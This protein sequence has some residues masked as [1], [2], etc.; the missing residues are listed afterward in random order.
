MTNNFKI[1]FYHK[2]TLIKKIGAKSG[3]YFN[4]IVGSSSSSKVIIDEN[5]ISAEHIQI[6]FSKEGLFIQD[7][8]SLNGTYVNGKKIKALELVKIDLNDRINLTKSENILINIV[9]FSSTT[10]SLNDGA[11]ENILSK[12][13]SVTIG[14]SKNCDIVLE[15][16]SISR[17]H[18]TIEK[19]QNGY[20]IID[21]NSLN[22]IFINGRRIKGTVEISSTDVIFIGKHKLS[23]KGDIS[24]I[25][26]QLA[27]YAK[28]IEKVY[29]NGVKGLKSVDLAIP[30]NTLLAIMGPSGCGKSTLL[31]ALNGDSPPTKGKVFLYNLELTQ[32]Y[33]YLKTQI[34]YVPQDDI[35]HSQLT[36]YQCLYYSAK[37]RLCDASN[38][39]I[40]KKIN[41]V[42]NEL[43]IFEKKDNY[44]SELSGG[45]RKRVSIAVELLSDPSLL[46]LDEPT[47]PLDPS[48]ID[49]FLQILKNLSKKGTTVIMVTHK[50]EDLE[51]MDEVVFLSTN[52]EMA[53]NGP[54]KAYKT[55][56]NVQSPVA[57]FQQLIGK[58]AKF[59]V[60]K[61]SE[62]RSQQDFLNSKE[63]KGIKNQS[64][65]SALYQFYWLFIRYF[66]IKTQDKGNFKLMLVQAPII[67]VLICLIFSDVSGAIPFITSIA[68]V[69][70]G[71]NNSAKEVV[72]EL[73]I[74]KRE[75]MYNLSIFP[76][77]FSKI[78]V[79]CLF[80]IIQSAVY[81]SI[82]FFRFQGSKILFENPL[83]AFL[84]M[85]F[86]A[87]VSTLFGLVISSFAN[88]TEKVM[89]IIPIVL[90][91]QIMLAGLITKINSFVVELISYLTISRWS[92]E[93][94]NIIQ[95]KIL[96]TVSII[97]PTDPSKT[98][99]EKKELDALKVLNDQFHT[100]YQDIPMNGTLI[101]DSFV[102]VFMAVLFTFTIY[103]SLKSKDP[104]NI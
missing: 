85:S 83:Q 87:I 52:G 8:N 31:K 55:Y 13:N 61:F 49:D 64:D 96:E 73:S 7:L 42:L 76:Y 37:L 66:K 93:G 92:T 28:G 22:G 38:D 17:H 40:S 47:S 57:V 60:D 5:S 77:I 54:A 2:N 24:N 29:R 1:L 69:W 62:G 80:S 81:I 35:I 48:V 86:V 104:L 43:Q 102:L 53:Y 30:S 78:T 39:S 32:N 18:A 103:Y 74:Y 46:F 9:Q 84:W 45:Q 95:K 90:I 82:L 98:I 97:D 21:N 44:I 79:L 33:E 20:Q 71:V 94:F 70:F 34:G 12:K 10:E 25:S 56:F 51:Y 68:A 59:W 75:R 89:T 50:P 16:H 19:I 63:S 91:P 14:R 26:D 58:N 23:I 101:L 4:F 15:S 36:V 100:S 72:S 99:S 41:Q 27:V 6:I 3:V 11:L 67:A 88:S 65:K